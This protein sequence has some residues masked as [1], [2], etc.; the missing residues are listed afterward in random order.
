MPRVPIGSVHEASASTTEASEYACAH[1]GIRAR[2]LS[3]GESRATAF[4]PLF[5]RGEGAAREAREAA[6]QYAI[7]DADENVRIAPCPQCGRRQ[8][9]AGLRYWGLFGFAAALPLLAAP[10]VSGFAYLVWGT[11][12]AVAAALVLTA[13]SALIFRAAYRKWTGTS[14]TV[15]FEVV[16]KPSKRPPSG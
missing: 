6:Q 13:G 1:C 15:V 5:L 8:P 16:S 4:S 3:R 14:D 7:S 9:R 10:F 2:A 11:V 12:Q